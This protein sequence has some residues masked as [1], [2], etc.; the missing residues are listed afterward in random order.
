MKRW[1]TL[2][3]SSVN[4]GVFAR[5]TFA[6]RGAAGHRGQHQPA[7][8]ASRERDFRLASKTTVCER[9]DAARTMFRNILAAVDGSVDSARAV[10][11]A[12]DLALKEEARLTL[13]SVGA[14]PTIWP[15]PFPIVLT[16][17][18]LN[19]GAQA[20]IDKV[21]DQVPA[22]V[23]FTRVVRVGRP[24]EEIV[25]EAQEGEYDLIVMGARGRGAAPSL[26]L[27]SVS[28]GVLNQCPAAVL[29]VHADEAEQT[30]A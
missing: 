7:T 9:S 30:A 28:H 3:A 25:A 14:P 29:I 11:Q 10:V 13:I 4:L 5:A 27:G 24:A 15:S 16:N 2:F 8:P 1:L 23:P 22:A 17:A 19:A 18:E 12:A 21:T 20:M 26:L 6:A